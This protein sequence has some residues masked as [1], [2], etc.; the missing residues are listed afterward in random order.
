[1][2]WIK[3]SPFHDFATAFSFTTGEIFLGYTQENLV[4]LGI[5]PQAAVPLS[6]K[7]KAINE[8]SNRASTSEPSTSECVDNGLLYR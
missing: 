1:V 5:P 3:A 7:I 6:L 8:A 2:A 4:A